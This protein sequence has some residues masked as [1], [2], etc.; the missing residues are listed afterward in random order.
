MGTCSIGTITPNFSWLTSQYT[1]NFSSTMEMQNRPLLLIDG[2]SMTVDLLMEL[3]QGKFTVDLAPEAWERV[4]KA[5]KMV[6]D[7]L[8]GHKTVYGINTGFGNF[9]DV[10]I[11]DDKV[12]ELQENL[13]RSHSAGMGDPLSPQQVRR[14]MALRINVLA[15]GTS[16]TF[17]FENYLKNT[18]NYPGHSGVSESTLKKYIECFN[19]DCLSYVPQVNS[20]AKRRGQMS[21][22]ITWFN[23]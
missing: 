12:E 7:I 9:A 2:V 17:Q 18:E 10:K 19:K 13:I 21:R 8:A 15:K 20:F 1:T 4:A 3:G 23:Y 5:R 11:S 6:D 22:Q 14:L 16:D